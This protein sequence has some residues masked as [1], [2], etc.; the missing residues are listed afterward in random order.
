[1]IGSTLGP[2][3]RRIRE[4]VTGSILTFNGIT[5][6]EYLK[7]S[8]NTIISATPTGILGSAIQYPPL[9]PVSPLDDFAASS[10]D[11]R[12]SAHSSGGSFATTDCITQARDGSHLR[13]MLDEKMGA[14]YWTQSNTDFDFKVGGMRGFGFLDGINDGMFGIAALN[15]SGTGVGIVVYNDGNAYLANITTWNYASLLQTLTNLGH[16][17][18][19]S[20]EYWLRLVRTT[21]SWKAYGSL[22]GSAWGTS[23]SS[24]SV[25]ITVDRLVIGQLFNSGTATAYKGAI[26]CDWIDVT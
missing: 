11:A 6:G 25:T 1:M 10:L 21:N 19:P 20:T 2:I 5:D 15:S 4:S 16:N 26:E 22:G 3:A 13:I 9:K 18:A 23:T 7:R 24:S 17:R 14:L 12:Y 8:G